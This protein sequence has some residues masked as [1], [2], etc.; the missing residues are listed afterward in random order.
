MKSDHEV[1]YHILAKMLFLPKS[2]Q[3]FLVC[4]LGRYPEL[5]DTVKEI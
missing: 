1:G 4:D 3:G 5:L 2:K